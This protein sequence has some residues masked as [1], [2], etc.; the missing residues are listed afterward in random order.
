MGGLQ[1]ERVTTRIVWVQDYEIM[2][3]D[4]RP[5]EKEGEGRITRSHIALCA[6]LVQDGPGL[7]GR[8]RSELHESRLYEEAKMIKC[9]QIMQR[10]IEK[11]SS[12]LSCRAASTDIPDPVSPLFPIVHRLWQVFRATSR[13]LTWLLYVCSSWLSSFFSPICGGP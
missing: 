3:L 7:R 11:S 9:F 1:E 4:F 8:E 5:R 10:S 12:S 6:G 13:I 2:T